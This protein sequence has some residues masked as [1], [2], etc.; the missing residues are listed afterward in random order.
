MEQCLGVVVSIVAL[1]FC[2]YPLRIL[3]QTSGEGASP[4]SANPIAV[5][6]LDDPALIGSR[7]L[8]ERDPIHPEGPGRW[9]KV[10]SCGPCNPILR[11]SPIAGVAGGVV[12]G[13]VLAVIHGGDELM[14]EED[15]KLVEVH[16]QAVA[17]ESAAP[18]EF[19]AV[20]LRSTG[21]IIRA[22]A[23]GPGRAEFA[24]ETERRP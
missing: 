24:Q 3:A 15:S 9:L 14:I 22:V 21:K 23:V 5:R 2:A 19:I 20:R 18:G 1:A 11:N 12:A 6:I 13:Y 4:R 10:P 17:L 7:W 8:L 16:L